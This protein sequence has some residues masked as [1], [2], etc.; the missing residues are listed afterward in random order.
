MPLDNLLEAV[1]MHAIAVIIEYIAHLKK[2][3][4]VPAA[5]LN[6]ERFFLL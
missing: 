5:A 2:Q 3:V 1:C 6:D 4:I